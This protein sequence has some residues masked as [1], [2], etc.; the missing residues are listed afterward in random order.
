MGAGGCDARWAS[1]EQEARLRPAEGRWLIAVETSRGRWICDSSTTRIAESA[2]NRA[3]RRRRPP[4][5]IGALGTASADAHFVAARRSGDQ[6]VT[7]G[8]RR[9]RPAVLAMTFFTGMVEREA[10]CRS[11][12]AYVARSRASGDSGNPP[13][14]AVV[15][16]GDD[17][18]VAPAGDSSSTSLTQRGT[19]MGGREM[20]CLCRRSA[21]SRHIRTNAPPR[22]AASGRSRSAAANTVRPMPPVWATGR[23]PLE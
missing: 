7:T 1:P 20:P 6:P 9:R 13:R 19:T 15:S 22:P 17:D 10:R 23:T 18:A 11:R 21:A 5:H 2:L 12:A 16:D 3:A 4:N 8:D 14:T